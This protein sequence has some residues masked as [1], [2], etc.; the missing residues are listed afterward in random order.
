MGRIPQ[1]KVDEIYNTMDVLEIVSDY[2]PLKKRGQN[3]W[4][5][6]PFSNEK[7]PSFA[8]NPAKG[9]YKD[10]SSGKGGNA[11]S[12]LMEMEGY[13]YAE[14]LRHIARRYGIEVEE[15]EEDP[16]EKERK[17]H[18]ESLY[19]V[20]EFAS[21][22]FH[23]QLTQTETGRKIG[24]SYFKERG[25]LDATIETFQLGY[26][27][28]AWEAFVLAAR[29]KQYQDAFLEELGLA[30]RSA[31]TG[32]LI[33]RFRGR[34]IFPI[35]NAIGKV[36]GFGGRILGKQKDIAKYINSP[37]SPIYHK[38]HVLYGLYQ[39]KKYIREEDLCILTEGYMDTVILHQHGVRNVVAS[40]G[41]ALTPEQIRLMRRFTPH[42][43][44][45]YDG[46]A[47]GVKAALRGID[48]LIEEGMAPK[49]VI[50]PG[51]HDPDSYIQ[52]VGTDAFRA[53]LKDHALNFVDFKI[54]ALSRDHPNPQDPEHQTLLIKELAQTVARI[55]DLVQRQVY[56][57]QVAQQVDITE[58]LMTH[59]VSEAR[60]EQDQLH[61]REARREASR[62]TLTGPPPE[63]EV[64]EFRA[65]EQ[66]ELASQ[67]KELLRVLLNHFDKTFEEVDALN[68]PLEDAQGNPT[69]LEETALVE[70]FEVE[71]EGLQFENQVFEQ[72]KNELFA[73]FQEGQSLNIHRYLNHEDVAISRL[74]AEL[75]T[76]PYEISPH[77]RRHGAFVL[78]L[79]EN[80]ERTVKS[81]MYHYKNKK[82]QRLIREAQDRIR[83]LSAHD[84]PE[85]DTFLQAYQNLLN[86]AKTLNKK[87]GLEGAI[88][89]RDGKL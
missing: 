75:L 56:V 64:K 29:E 54:Q 85:L 12:F 46:D 31:K 17:D 48:L 81:A 38:S 15:E 25:L 14:A 40:S 41:T 70:F 72:L 53:F 84:S 45:I 60:R 23:G 7:T 73:R 74:V 71:L 57:K 26:A 11:V 44:M 89:A 16:A 33:D 20:N 24:L 83:E 67:E 42:V 51:N 35:T 37:E 6:S 58:A 18:R 65:F 32:K 78:D 21:R 82:L 80:L 49:V 77:W 47:A 36:V 8:V 87:L 27:P 86:M 39:A 1:Q 63:A 3:Y 10:F 52:E 69:E 55:P 88:Q 22:Y 66:L 9:I 68:G 34:V 79:D 5:L 13:T 61:A 50:L 62:Q 30:S 43:L 4:A 28:D 2:L 76:F 59:A 19:I